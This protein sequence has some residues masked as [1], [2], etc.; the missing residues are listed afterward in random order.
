MGSAA[1]VGSLWRFQI[2]FLSVYSVKFL[3]IQKSEEYFFL[4]M[5]EPKEFVVEVALEIPNTHHITS[6]DHSSF[7][8]HCFQCGESIY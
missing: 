7:L 1:P 5:S 8:I 4:L 3:V 2:P 6:D